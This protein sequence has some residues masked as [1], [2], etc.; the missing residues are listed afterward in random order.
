MAG[1]VEQ[2]LDDY[3]LVKQLGAGSFGTVYL[4][5]HMYRKTQV[6]IKVLPL[7]DN[8]D[9]PTFLNEARTFRLRHPNIVQILDFG[10]EKETHTPFLVMEYAPNGS[11]RQHYPQGT[12]LPLLTII[13]YVRQVASAL[14]YAHNERLIHRDVK[15]ANMLLGSH[16]E[17]LLSDFGAA[18]IAHSSFFRITQNVIGTALYMA[19]EQLLGKPCFASDQYALGTVV[20]EWLCGDTPFHGSFFELYNLHLH[21]S[22]P[23]LATR[24][25]AISPDVEQVVMRALA[26]DPQQ[27]FTTVQ[28]FAEA[29]ERCS[30]AVSPK[31]F[32]PAVATL[33][34]VYRPQQTEAVFLPHALPAT[35]AVPSGRTAPP[36]RGISRRR[37]IGVSL[38]LIVAGGMTWLVV[39]E[40]GHIG[41]Q[42]P[43]P[44]STPTP[45]PS[46]TTVLTYTGHKNEVFTVAWSPDSQRIASAGGNACV[47]AASGTCQR[48][49]DT[50]VHVWEA[51]TGNLIHSYSGHSTVVRSVAWSPDG[52]RIASGS[53]DKTVQVWDATTGSNVRTYSGHHDWVYAVAW[54]LGDKFIASAS[55]DSTVQVWDATTAGGI[56]SYTY[57][58]HKGQVFTVAWSPDGKRIVSGGEDTTVQVWDATSGGNVQTFRGHT[59]YVGAVAWSPD[60]NYIASGSYDN[61]VRVWDVTTGNTINTYDINDGY[62]SGQVYTVTWSPD[63]KYIA[64]GGDDTT[65]QVW[66]AR[67]GKHICT[68]AEHHQPIIAACWSPAGKYIASGGFDDKVRVW[69]PPRGIE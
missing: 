43:T 28:A 55:K 49:G 63:S 48:T 68:Y 3:R 19:P 53:E 60:G 62:S 34:P 39:N 2:Q 22:P 54:Y 41:A 52:K 5:E 10:V 69:Q 45:A 23:S 7:L 32:L 35:V 51:R 58:G 42:P 46:I 29:L 15:P 65:I 57:T 64:F 33:P 38:G 24:M 17:V 25:P 56:Y 14:Q 30:Q 27:R 13:A 44:I 47:G 9:L 26:K 59:S 21:A 31:L 66:D 1:Y 12:R 61:S 36:K 18:L 40:L 37:F 20:Y 67:T 4:G 16:N 8:D 6:A 50:T 11:L